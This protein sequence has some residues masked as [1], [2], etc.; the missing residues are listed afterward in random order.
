MKKLLML[1]AL[2]LVVQTAPVLAEHHEGGEGKKKG[3]FSQVD[4]N[5]DGSISK[6]EYLAHSE[7]KFTE[8]DLDGDGEISPEEAKKHREAKRE[9]MKEM[10]EKM[11]EKRAERKAEKE[12]TSEE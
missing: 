5:G 9:K 3:S 1:A 7:K 4:T 8:K 6:A 10:R 11:K 2:G 12:A